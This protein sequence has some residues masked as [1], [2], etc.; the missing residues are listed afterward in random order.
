MK[1]Y[2]FFS[3]DARISLNY[4]KSSVLCLNNLEISNNRIKQ[5]EE[6]KILGITFKK[7]WDETVSCVYNIQLNNIKRSLFV[8]KFRNLNLIQKIWMLNNFILSKLWYVA[9]VI[10]APNK[11]IAEITKIIGIFL[12]MGHLFKINRNQL[13]LPNEKGG[14][15]LTDVGN[16]IKALFIRDILYTSVKNGS[17]PS[18][19]FLFKNR[20]KLKLERTFNIYRIQ[21]LN[22][23]KQ[24]YLYLIENMRILPA[25]EVKNTNIIWQNVWLNLNMKFIDSNL[26]T[27]IYYFMNGIVPTRSKLIRHKIR[28]TEDDNCK[29]CDKLDDAEHRLK[30][31]QN[32]INVW[33][34][35]LELLEKKIKN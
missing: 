3:K 20:N 12:W 6:I 16:K 34:F 15:A 4:E 22:T 18:Q 1:Q 27:A 19:E 25:V 29:I 30:T 2:F 14:L 21:F 32:S 8:A 17:I 24:I 10:P 13:Y 26:K 11:F 7:T 35:V 28:G 5:V 33:K 9:Q 23:T 31:C